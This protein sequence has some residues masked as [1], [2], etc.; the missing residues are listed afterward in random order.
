MVGSILDAVKDWQWQSM[1]FLFDTIEFKITE[2]LRN[3]FMAN[4]IFILVCA[5]LYKLDIA[6]NNRKRVS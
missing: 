5:I 3:V 1:D 2:V 6:I 4:V